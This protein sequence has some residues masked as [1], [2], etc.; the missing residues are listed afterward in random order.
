MCRGWRS[1]GCL[2][3]AVPGGCE[4]G[5]PEEEDEDGAGNR[6]VNAWRACHDAGILHAQRPAE[7]CGALSSHAILTQA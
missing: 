6:R 7:P 3:L 4:D 5:N 1:G 2:L